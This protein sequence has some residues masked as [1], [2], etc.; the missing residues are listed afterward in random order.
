MPKRPFFKTCKVC[1]AH[2]DPQE[3]CDCQRPVPFTPKDGNRASC[4]YFSH[5]T[6]HKQVYKIHCAHPV[7]FHC[8]CFSS[9]MVQERDAFYA[10]VCCKSGRGC[11]IWAD[12]E[13]AYAEWEAEH[14]DQWRA[15]DA[16]VTEK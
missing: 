1:G 2:L 8:G 11:R 14:G 12:I 10:T 6:N 7:G 16:G 4:P 13:I 3:S 15:E 9:A 5:R